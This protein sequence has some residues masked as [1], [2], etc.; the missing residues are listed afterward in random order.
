MTV[1]WARVEPRADLIDEVA[2]ER[3][4]NALLH[5]KDLG[6]RVTVV[7]V[8]AVWP[9]WLG[10]EAWVLPWVRGAF[11]RHLARL[12]ER[13]GDCFDGVIA[14]SQADS[15]VELGYL[16][17]G[18]PPWRRRERLDAREARTSIASMEDAL[19]RH[20]LLGPKLVSGWREVPAHLPSSAWPPVVSDARRASEVHIKSLVRGAGPTA[21][22][23]GLLEWR[24]G[25]V[26]SSPPTALL[27][28]W[29][30]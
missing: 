2:W 27:E 15:L 17:G 3:Y 25:A 8:D 13:L 1:E 7:M 9:A 12:G 10:P 19:K 24:N 20:P 21:S 28:L 4:R 5:A 22:T 18:V 23:A 11:A 29:R 14:F 26:V 30:A 6:L 16:R